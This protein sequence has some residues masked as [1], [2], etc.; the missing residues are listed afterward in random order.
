MND[1]LVSKTIATMDEAVS[2]VTTGAVQEV[3]T[4]NFWD[5]SVWGFINIISVLDD[6]TF[7]F[8]VTLPPL[9]R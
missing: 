3:Q 9:D 2:A 1:S 8:H 4:V 6:C 5:S 7:K